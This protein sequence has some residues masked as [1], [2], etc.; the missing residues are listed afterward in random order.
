[1]IEDTLQSILDEMHDIFGRAV[2][3]NNRRQ[4]M[5]ANNIHADVNWSFAL[6]VDDIIRNR[7][8]AK[9]IG[10]TGVAKLFCHLADARGL[11]CDV[12]TM[13]RL[14]DWRREYDASHGITPQTGSVVINGHQIIAVNTPDG[15]RM[16]DPMGQKL[17]FIKDCPTVGRIVDVNRCDYLV[18]AIVSGAE[19]MHVDTYWKLD[20]IYRSGNVKI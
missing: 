9:V 4:Y 19:F 18:C 14:V 8:P 20:A 16:F 3:P 10:C 11:R 6:T 1:M 2:G 12:V 15:M 13:A 17:H 5:A 7:I